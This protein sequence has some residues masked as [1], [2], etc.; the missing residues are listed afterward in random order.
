MAPRAPGIVII[1]SCC[2]SSTLC[3]ILTMSASRLLEQ[4][5]AEAL[6]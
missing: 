1:N 6:I 4:D 2:F 5:N 3:V